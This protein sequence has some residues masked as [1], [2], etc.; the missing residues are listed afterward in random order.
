MFLSTYPKSNRFNYRLAESG[1]STSN[2]N[3]LIFLDLQMDYFPQTWIY[4]KEGIMSLK[5]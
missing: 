5:I 2:A 3:Y 1:K 4:K